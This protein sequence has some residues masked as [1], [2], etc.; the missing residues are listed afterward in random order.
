MIQDL[1]LGY[2]YKG[3]TLVVEPLPEH[4]KKEL[5]SLQP[6]NIHPK[7]NN[8][9]ISGFLGAKPLNR[10]G[11]VRGSG[12][13]CNEVSSREKPRFGVGGFLS[14]RNRVPRARP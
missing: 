1:L 10:A 9:A 6:I 4:R 11:K 14:P 7:N 5:V 13:T 12:G 3:G 8:C 2:Q